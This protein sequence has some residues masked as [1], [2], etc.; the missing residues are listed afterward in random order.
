MKKRKGSKKKWEAVR[1]RHLNAN[2]GH[3][4]NARSYTRG[5]CK[6]CW[7]LATRGHSFMPREVRDRDGLL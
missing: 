4:L 1:D 7:S 3:V 6:R 2:P 5:D